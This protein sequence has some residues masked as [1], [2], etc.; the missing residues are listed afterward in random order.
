MRSVVQLQPGELRSCVGCHEDRKSAPP[1]RATIA[2]RRAPSR[3]G[4]SS[5]GAEA[6]SYEKIVQPVWD[7]KCVRCHDANDKRGFNLT[8]ARDGE[9]VPASYRTLISGGWVHYFN[10]GYGVRH[11]KAES[12][13]FGTVKSKLWPILDRGHYDVKLTRDEMHRIK[14]WTDLNCPLWPDYTYRPDRPGPEAK[15]MPPKR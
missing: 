14:C 7:A 1:V 5:W 13:T 15:A 9:R 11:Q 4:S 12:L 8:G 6:F 10:W 2:S 3:L